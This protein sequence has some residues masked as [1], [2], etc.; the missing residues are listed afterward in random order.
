MLRILEKQYK[1]YEALEYVE[2]VIKGNKILHPYIYHLKGNLLMHHIQFRKAIP[3][4]EKANVEF[5]KIYKSNGFSFSNYNIGLCYEKLGDIEQ[6][7][8]YY[9]K[10]IVNL[11]SAEA[12]N[13]L[14]HAYHSA[15]EKS[16]SKK[17]LDTAESYYKKSL[18]AKPEYTIAT[19]NLGM[20]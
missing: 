20:L 12:L 10:S 17:L 1:Y 7:I 14:G 18:Q 16:K 6:A 5:H 2:K 13:A 9:E 8:K 15:F 4:F 11:P 19:F 3:E